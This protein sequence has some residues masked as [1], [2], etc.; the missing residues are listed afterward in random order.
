MFKLFKIILLIFLLEI[1]YNL[2]NSNEVLKTLFIIHRHG[3]RS[4]EYTSKSCP[5]DSNLKNLKKSYPDGA[6]QLLEKGKEH[7]FR[8]GQLIRNRYDQFLDDIDIRKIQIKSS[9]SDRC[10]EST[11]VIKKKI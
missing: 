11:E 9:D 3:D 5:N 6:G 7:M 2:V 8:I 1:D 4:T 10:I